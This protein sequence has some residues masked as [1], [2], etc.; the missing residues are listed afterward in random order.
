MPLWQSLNMW[1][2]Q[3]KYGLHDLP[4]VEEITLRRYVKF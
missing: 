4:K 3:E 1:I 2:D